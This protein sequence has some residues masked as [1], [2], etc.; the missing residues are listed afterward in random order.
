MREAKIGTW[1]V[2]ILAC[3]ACRGAVRQEARFIV[4]R[5][6]GRGYP[7]RSGIPVML[8][9]EARPPVDKRR[10]CSNGADF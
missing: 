1:L 4:C 7:I 5:A 2:S 6:C 9:E 8:V 3:P 10:E